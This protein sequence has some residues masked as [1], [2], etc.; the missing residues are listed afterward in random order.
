MST[1]ETSEGGDSKGLEELVWASQDRTLSTRS[2]KLP[3]NGS[4]NKGSKVGKGKFSTSGVSAVAPR[5]N[6][7]VTRANAAT[8][9]PVRDSAGGP[10]RRR[11][12]CHACL[13]EC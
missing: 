1:E 11:H 6:F 3:E 13:P 4:G 10:G 5:A 8:W 9:W 7:R 12:A 2:G